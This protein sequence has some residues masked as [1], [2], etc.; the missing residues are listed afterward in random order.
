MAP[1]HAARAPAAYCV[2]AHVTV[3]G[4]SKRL[5]A[6][7]C[8]CSCSKHRCGLRCQASS[9]W[10]N[11]LLLQSNLPGLLAASQAA[12]CDRRW[13]CDKGDRALL[14]LWVPVGTSG[15]VFGPLHAGRCLRRRLRAQLE[16]G[17]RPWKG[18][19][20]VLEQSMFAK[21]EASCQPR[22]LTVSTADAARLCMLPR[23]APSNADNA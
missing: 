6:R 1:M 3:D 5:R 4:G 8:C 12:S 17:R 18:L 7:S 10:I 19:L 14:H 9:L 15:T 11:H 2:F 16:S 20:Y 22:V 13:P 21:A 23:C